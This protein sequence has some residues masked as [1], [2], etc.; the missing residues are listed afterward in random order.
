MRSI[1]QEE[2]RAA[3]ANFWKVFSG[4][5]KSE[6]EELYFPSS[7][8]FSSTAPR[9]EPGRLMVARR[10]RQFFD[11]QVSVRADLGTI[12]VQSLSTN[13]A[14]ATYVYAVHVTTTNRDKTR[15]RRTAPFSRATQIFQRD[16]TGK[17]RIIHEHMSSATAPTVETLGPD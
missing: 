9:T 1:S 10:A 2:V 17:L 16:D 11:S 15:T 4:K 12:E 14:I 3:V 5:S 6:F 13:V 8:V 7:T